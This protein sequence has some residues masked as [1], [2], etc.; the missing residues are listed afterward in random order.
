VLLF[1]RK[2]MKADE[3]CRHARPK[4]GDKLGIID[5][6]YQYTMLAAAWH[7]AAR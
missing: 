7:R 3:F 1:N 5:I 2:L 6:Q 4:H